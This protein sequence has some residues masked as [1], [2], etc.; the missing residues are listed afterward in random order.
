MF[1]I[2]YIMIFFGQMRIPDRLLSKIWFL[3]RRSMGFDIRYLGH[4]PEDN[5]DTRNLASLLQLYNTYK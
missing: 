5:T 4:R 2:S 3:P 1:E